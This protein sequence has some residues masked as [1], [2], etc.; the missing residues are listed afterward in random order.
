MKLCGNGTC[1]RFIESPTGYRQCQN[2]AQWGKTTCS[3][4]STEAQKR[5]IKKH[6]N[7]ARNRQKAIIQE[8]LQ[9]QRDQKEFALLRQLELHIRDNNK[10][11]IHST[12]QAMLAL[13]DAHRQGK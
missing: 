4:H 1:A 2:R 12:V 13:L 6:F 8:K 9:D 3:Q 5:R 10:K 11:Y 7:D